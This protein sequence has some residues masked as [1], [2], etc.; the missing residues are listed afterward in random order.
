[1]AFAHAGLIDL[2]TIRR[3]YEAVKEDLEVQERKILLWQ[4][5][6]QAQTQLQSRPQRVSCDSASKL[7][8]S[9]E[10]MAV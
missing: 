6:A 7:N 5:Q 8:S 9:M 1:M 10:K 3:K 2:D 4:S